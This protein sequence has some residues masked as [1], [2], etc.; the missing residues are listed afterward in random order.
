VSAACDSRA[1]AA[2]TDATRIL[3]CDIPARPVSITRC[4][5]A[6]PFSQTLVGGVGQPRA[7]KSDARQPSQA[8]TQGTRRA[9]A[10]KRSRSAPTT[11]RTLT[12]ESD[13]RGPSGPRTPGSVVSEKHASDREVPRM[14]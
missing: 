1:T 7:H 8:R 2:T 9:N 3:Q 5:T 6:T 13:V 10:H 11:V 12:H 4:R 14:G